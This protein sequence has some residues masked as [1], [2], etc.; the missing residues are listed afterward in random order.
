MPYLSVFFLLLCVLV[1]VRARVC[2]GR[3][4]AVPTS[5][6]FAFLYVLLIPLASLLALS[7]SRGQPYA[8]VLTHERSAIFRHPEGKNEQHAHERAYAFA[9]AST[10]GPSSWC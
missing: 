3:P 5:L 4:V 2:R 8:P 7:V 9:R 10:R 6:F 1:L